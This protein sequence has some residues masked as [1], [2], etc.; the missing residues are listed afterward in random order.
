MIITLR[1]IDKNIYVTGKM[2][3]KMR[4][5]LLTNM[6]YDLIYIEDMKIDDYVTIEE[7]D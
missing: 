1:Q 6:K 3:V 4:T 5:L 2:K 7:I